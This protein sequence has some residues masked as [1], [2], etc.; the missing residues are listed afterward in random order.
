[1]RYRLVV[2]VALALAMAALS[3]GL[4][5]PTPTIDSDLVAT[6]VAKTLGP[7]Q[8][9]ADHVATSIAETLTAAPSPPTPTATT[10]P[11][12]TAVPPTSPPPPPPLLRIVYT[13]NG[14]IWLI[15]GSNP[16]TQLTSSGDADQVLISS[17]GQKVAFVRHNDAT[18]TEQL[19]SVNHDGTGEITLLNQAQLDALH[20]LGPALHN[21][22][23]NLR[24][25]PG[26]H[27]LLF[28]TQAI[29]E[30]P[31]L[32]L[33][34]D[35]IQVDA[36][37]G[38]VTTVLTPGNGGMFEVSPDG[39]QIAISRPT[40]I[41]LA[42]TDG[43]NIR[44]DLV[45]FPSIITY[46]EFQY[47]PPPVWAPDS[48]AVGIAIP[49]EDPLTSPTYGTI[50][51]IPANGDPPINLAII[52]GEFYFS[53]LSR[54]A[55]FSPDLSK[56]AYRVETGTPN[57]YELRISN[58]DGSAP[59]SYFT[60]EIT[61]QGWNPDSMNFVYS[62]G[63]TNMQLGKVGLA[64]LPLAVGIRLRWIT[65]TEYLYLAGSFGSWT[66]RKGELGGSDIPLASPSGDFVQY[67]FDR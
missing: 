13:D 10:T 66:L 57:I 45:T 36:D 9:P 61:W 20:P 43:S 33:Y 52:T 30:G 2:V 55:S 59:T 48:S 34:E 1:M 35:L 64:P 26:T 24:F 3:C 8:P 18:G 47:R 44:A 53:Q 39:S 31:G 63:P 15:E 50:W 25:V 41:S 5:T 7:D 6:E 16:P 58:A 23:N 49:S 60:G 42:N 22:P 27:N 67:D 40:S 46:S 65:P 38:T 62:I 37:T 29:F 56:L 17:D 21:I 51:R 54:G 19:R 28:T 14:N 32:A 11:S 4:P 12:P